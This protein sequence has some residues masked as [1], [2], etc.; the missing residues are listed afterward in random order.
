MATQTRAAKCWFKKRRSA[1][2]ITPSQRFGFCAVQ[3]TERTGQ[4]VATFTS[5]DALM[6]AA[7]QSYKNSPSVSQRVLFATATKPR[8][9]PLW[10]PAIIAKLWENE[11]V[12]AEEQGPTTSELLY[13][14]ERPRQSFCRPCLRTLAQEDQPTVR[15]EIKSVKA[16]A[17][18]VGRAYLEGPD[19]CSGCGRRTT[20][21]RSG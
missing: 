7:N 10:W 9:G 18:V 16:A 3:R 12:M 1:A 14:H 21:L 11:N 17:L 8:P 2:P 4:I 13:L 15:A 5:A 19:I 20:V 6:K